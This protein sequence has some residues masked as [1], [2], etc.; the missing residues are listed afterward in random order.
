LVVNV[1]LRSDL[2]TKAQVPRGFVG[3]QGCAD[4]SLYRR[5][6]Q[7]GLTHVQ[8]W[9]QFAASE[10][11]ETP[12]AQFAHGAIVGALSAEEAEEWRAG[13]A[14]AVADGTYFIAQP[15]HCAVG[16]KLARRS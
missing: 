13:M 15:F 2:K 9:P 11:P 7:T 8:M 5:F 10:R 4:A 6:H 1:P 3:A 14:Q 12:H 16:I